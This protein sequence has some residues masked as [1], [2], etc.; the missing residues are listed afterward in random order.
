VQNEGSV[1]TI[2]ANTTV[3]LVDQPLPARS[4][5]SNLMQ[6]RELEGAPLHLTLMAQ[7]ANEADQGP[8]STT[9][10]TGDH[11][12]ARGEY[13]IPEFS[14]DVTYDAASDDAAVDIG[15]IPLPNLRQGEALAGDYGVLQQ[16]TVRMVNTAAR[17][18][19]VALY[20]NPRGG[21]ATGTFL[22][23]RVL[24]QA[25]AMAPFTNYKLREYTIPGNGYVS[26]TIVTMPE[27]GSSYPLRL[28]IGPDDGS[29]SPGA[30]G[31]PVY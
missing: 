26:T 12:H 6:L 21:R 8:A 28:T 10:L 16:I 13:Q 17:P 31:S 20:A 23:D 1:V 5:V 24:V 7:N 30:P 27:G 18:A 29:V 19:R 9:L 22:I 11:P 25:H 4:V 15:R 3:D 14:Y 2:P